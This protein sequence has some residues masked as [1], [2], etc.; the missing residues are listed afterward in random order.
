MYRHYTA[1][2]GGCG[3]G[4]REVGGLLGGSITLG[5]TVDPVEL[6]S[7]PVGLHGVQQSHLRSLMNITLDLVHIT[8]TMIDQ[9]PSSQ[10]KV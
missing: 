9:Q 5:K 4:E 2:S 3:V 8:S 6:R 1:Q 10:V 7:L